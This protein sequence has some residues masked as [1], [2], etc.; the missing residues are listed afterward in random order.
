MDSADT[1][2]LTVGTARLRRWLDGFAERHGAVAYDVTP[3]RAVASAADGSRA[4]IDV[5][6]PPLTV[7]DTLPVGGLLDHVERERRIGVVLVRR[8]GYAAGVFEGRRLV[9]SKVGSRQVQGR[10]AAGGWSQ[11]RFA[12]RREKQAREAFEAAADV[13][14]RVVLPYAKQLDAVVLG[15]DKQAV[16]QVLDDQR[17]E[18]LRALV[19]APHLNVPDPRLAVLRGTPERFLAATVQVSEPLA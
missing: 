4:E 14:V 10:T 6:F 11:Q 8:G 19:V 7:N 3:E 12:R 15:G 16:R 2:T 13:V 5:P 18:P 9:A 1:K 17:L